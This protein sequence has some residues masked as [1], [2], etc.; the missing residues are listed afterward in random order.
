M[1]GFETWL[2]PIRPSGIGC[3]PMKLWGA[4][5]LAT[6]LLAFAGCGSDSTTETTKI[7]KVGSETVTIP[8]DTRE[9]PFA[10]T[11]ALLAKTGYLPWYQ[12][13]I[14][15]QADRLLTPQRAEAIIHEPEPRRRVNEEAVFGQA[16]PHCRRPGRNIISPRATHSQLN[17]IRT[18]SA[19][20]F[21]IVLAREDASVRFQRCV[22]KGIESMPDG[23]LIELANTTGKVQEAVLEEL[24]APCA[25]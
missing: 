3:G 4:I 7:V 25:Q 16:E 24:L 18:T 13:C 22:K 23:D 12:H 15:G 20:A 10:V 14:L 19:V 9:G 8:E 21:Q 2:A 6:S 17:L 11:R 5:L 1:G